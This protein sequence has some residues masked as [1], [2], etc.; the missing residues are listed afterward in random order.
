LFFL[1]FSPLVL[2]LIQLFSRQNKKEMV[3]WTLDNWKARNWIL[4]FA[5]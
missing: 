5:I 4:L 2:I 1:L 3:V